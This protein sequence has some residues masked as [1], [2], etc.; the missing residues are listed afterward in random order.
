[1]LVSSLCNVD[2]VRR[3][4]G[5]IRA[6]AAYKSIKMPT[7][8]VDVLLLE[9]KPGAR[10]S[11]HSHP[12][13]E[14]FHVLSGQAIIIGDNN[15]FKIKKG[16]T[17]IVLPNEFYYLQNLEKELCVILLVESPPYDAKNITYKRQFSGHYP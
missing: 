10:T 9:I 8:N 5:L 12:N 2:I 16:D 6:L 3:P 13:E 4:Y 15:Q 17:V 1:M 7:H 14:I 11:N